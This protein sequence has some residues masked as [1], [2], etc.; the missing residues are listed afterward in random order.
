MDYETYLKKLDSICDL[1]LL[2]PIIYH[3][4]EAVSDNLR[5]MKTKTYKMVKMP[6][7]VLTET[8]ETLVS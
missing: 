1:V 7:I 6:H 5:G 4:Q 2:N 3:R 8:S